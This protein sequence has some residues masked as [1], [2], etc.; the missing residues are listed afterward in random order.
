MRWRT[1]PYY[2]QLDHIR[3]DLSEGNKCECCG[4]NGKQ[5]KHEKFGCAKC[6]T[7]VSGCCI[8]TNLLPLSDP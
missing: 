4:H 6:P 8:D 2:E 3:K 1:D 5:K 7:S